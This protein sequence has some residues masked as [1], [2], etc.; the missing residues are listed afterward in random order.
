MWQKLPSFITGSLRASAA[1]GVLV[2]VAGGALAGDAQPLDKER[3]F[4]AVLESDAAPEDKAMAC[5]RLAVV[6]SPAAVPALAKLLADEDLASWARIALEVIPGPEVDRALR[7]AMSRVRGGLLVGVIHS[8]GNRRDA[9][10]V[11]GLAVQ[12]DGSDPDVVAA[13]GVALGRIGGGAAAKVLESALT[14]VPAAARSEVAEGCILC[15]EGFLAAG[16]AG[17]AVRLYDLVRQTTVFKPRVLEATRGAI[18]ARGPAGLPLLLE[19]LRSS[20]EDRLSVGL[21]T[22]RELPGRE[23]TEALVTEVGLAAPERQ[24]LVLMAV[25]DRDDEAVLR[26]VTRLAASGSPAVRVVAVGILEERGGL[27]SLPALLKAAIDGDEAVADAAQLALARFG[28]AEV[29]ARLVSEMGEANGRLLAV[30]IEVAGLR[31]IESAVP[32]VVARVGDSNPE[33]R[34]ASVATLG[35]LGTSAQV[36]VLTPMFKDGLPARDRADLEKAIVSIAGR[37][38]P[39]S[40]PALLP[41]LQGASTPARLVGLHA[42]AAAGGPQALAA[43]VRAV[44]DPEETVQDEAVRTLVSWT[45][46]WPGDSAVAEPLLALAKSGRKAAHQVQG[47]RGYLQCL[48]E[49]RALSVERKLAAVEAVMP[50][51]Q[52]PEEKRLVIAVLGKVPTVGSLEHLMDFADDAAT[53]EEACL[54]IV[55]I[56]GGPR[57][58]AGAGDVRRKALQAVVDRSQN[59]RTRRK[60]RELL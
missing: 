11:E 35:A 53:L 38:G 23:V 4:I 55:E 2:V 10:A 36:P 43:V 9:N 25:G 15:A 59:E 3:E 46:T 13:A 34:R 19:Q 52:R 47:L 42:L 60:A 28:G 51:A 7:E 14:R 57:L 58:E 44:D 41:L 49:D 45:S 29:D 33:I 27:D 30:L 16:N 8:V 21:R 26:A 24:G 40:A 18:L 12:L 22:A 32:I 20:D 5:K 56:A 31:G 39:A 6:G 50:L 54:A 1:F 48:R 17:E 37:S